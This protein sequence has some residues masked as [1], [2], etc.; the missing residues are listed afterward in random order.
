MSLVQETTVGAKAPTR[1]TLTVRLAPGLTL[2][3]IRDSSGPWRIQVLTIDPSQPLTIQVATPGPMG[4]YARPSEIGRARGALAAI[5]G[6]FSASP[7]R[8]LHPITRGGVVRTTGRQTGAGFGARIRAGIVGVEHAEIS[9]RDETT[10]LSFRLAHVNAGRAGRNQVVAYTSYGGRAE[11]P[12]ARSCWVRLRPVGPRAWAPGR[13]A[14]VRRYHVTRQ[15]CTAAPAAVLRKTIVLSSRLR[16]PGSTI[17]RSMGLGDVIR[18]RSSTGWTGVLDSIGGA[19]LLVSEGLN[20]APTCSSYLCRQHPRTAIGVRADG[21]ILLVTVDGREARSVGMN[22]N[23]LAN[24]L[25][26]LGARYAVN[27]DGG[28]GSTMWTSSRGIV[29]HPSDPYG[30]R[31]VTSA[32][33]VLRGRVRAVRVMGASRLMT[34]VPVASAAE[35]AT[36]QSL[37][38]ADGGSTGGLLDL[39][40][41]LAQ[42]AAA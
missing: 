14:M 4:T 16:G 26:N 22:L 2:T 12:Q 39:I 15:G 5:N 9:A 34:Q 6:D 28:G 29:N 13:L 38:S 8:P 32:L 31:P 11:K 17:L 19:P 42:G 23:Q 10:A 35:A 33:V 36:A 24:L 41:E 1:R 30:E 3:H 40:A 37:A 21:K 27:L 20:V 7:G 18:L 25:R